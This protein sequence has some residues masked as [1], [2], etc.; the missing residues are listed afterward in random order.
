MRLLR[1]GYEMSPAIAAYAEAVWRR[2]SVRE[3]IEHARPPHA[4]S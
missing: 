4:P 3:Y 2:P 1:S